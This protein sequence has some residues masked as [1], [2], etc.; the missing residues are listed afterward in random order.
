VLLLTPRQI[1]APGVSTARHGT[2]AGPRW[3]RRQQLPVVVEATHSG[4]GGGSSPGTTI[5]RDE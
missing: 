1:R 3:L 4:G 2:A 5:L